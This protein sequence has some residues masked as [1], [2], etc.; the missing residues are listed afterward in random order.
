MSTTSSGPFG[1]SWFDNSDACIYHAP[2]L[3]ETVTLM[4]DRSPESRLQS[5]EDK[6]RNIEKD[7]SA[8]QGRLSVPTE[9]TSPILIVFLTICGTA[10]LWYL[11]WL[12]TTV[13]GLRTEIKTVSGDVQNLTTVMLPSALNAASNDPTNPTNIELVS[14]VLETAKQK[15]IPIRQ[16]AIVQAGTKFIEAA[17]TDQRAWP[18]AVQLIN[19]RST[20]TPASVPPFPQGRCLPVSPD[21]TGIVTTVG[22]VTL[23]GCVQDLDHVRWENVDFQNVTIVYH[24]GET[25]LQNVHF[26]NCQF[27]LAY[28]PPSQTLGESLLA[29]NAVSITLPTPTEPLLAR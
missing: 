3:S 18:A 6:L 29:S 19:Y 22:S 23:E 4:A 24:G 5:L 27:T 7:V 14:K 25:V 17:K 8:I 13:V 11:G 2:S 9:K 28:L 20:L 12:G 16:Q 1:T 26:I 21:A 10:M 15:N